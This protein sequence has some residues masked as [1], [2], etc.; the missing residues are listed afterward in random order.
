MA[1]LASTVVFISAMAFIIELIIIYLVTSMI[2]EENKSTI[3]LMKIFGYRKKEVS[4][5]I[6]NSSTIVVMAGFLIGIPLSFALMG[7]F[8]KTLEN[9]LIFSIS[10][11]I[12]PLYVIV[13]F[14]AVMLYYELSK[15]LCR[16]KV[17]AIS[18]SEALKA[19]TE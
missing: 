9:S 5:L 8:M 19:G 6:L 16:R 1:P 15:L 7:G 17:N 4:S 3:S 13:G 14:V 12:D 10:V 11:M 18:M 2:V